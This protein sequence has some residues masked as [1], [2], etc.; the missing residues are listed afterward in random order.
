MSLTIEISKIEHGQLFKNL[1]LQ[2]DVLEYFPMYD[3]REIDDSVRVWELFCKKGASLTALFDGVPCGLAYLN[4]QAYKKFSH[5]CLLTIIVDKEFRNRGIGTILLEKLFVLG[6][7]EF[8]LESLHLEV[9]ETNPAINLYKRLG[10]VEFGVH[11]K[12]IKEEG[13]YIGKIFMERKI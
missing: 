2:P 3:M 13:R 9:Y 10:F 12:F 11:P 5:Q 7:E 8:G 1:L 4:I 6:R